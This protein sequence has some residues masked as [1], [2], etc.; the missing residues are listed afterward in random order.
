MPLTSGLSGLNGSAMMLPKAIGPDG[1]YSN[2][3]A[4]GTRNHDRFGAISED[5]FGLLKIVRFAYGLAWRI[6]TIRREPPKVLCCKVCK[7]TS[8][9]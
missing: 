4:L 2:I 9:V 8:R 6:E 3:G 7:L 1:E 5:R